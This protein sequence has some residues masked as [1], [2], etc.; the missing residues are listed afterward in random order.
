MERQ[1]HQAA[2]TA[3]LEIAR[4]ISS[5]LDLTQC[6]NRICEITGKVL[7]ADRSSVILWSARKRAFIASAD[8]GTPPDL[9]ER[10][11]RET[12]SLQGSPHMSQLLAGEMAVMHRDADD[13]IALKMLDDL[14][15]SMQVI[16]P[17]TGP[18]VLG[19]LTLG[20]EAAAQLGPDDL[21][22][23]RGIAQQASVAINTARLFTNTQKAA[24]FRTRLSELA[25]QLSGERDLDRVIQQVAETARDAFGLDGAFLALAENGS[26]TVRAAAG[27]S[28]DGLVGRS[29]ASDAASSFTARAFREHRAVFVNR[30]QRSPEAGGPML[31]GLRVE[32]VLVAPL[33]A[34]EQPVGVLVLLDGNEPYRFGQVHAEEATILAA[35]AGA[36]I[37]NSRLLSALGRKSEE[38]QRANRALEDLIYVA[39]HDL[40]G[41]LINLEGFAHELAGNLGRVRALLN[42]HGTDVLRELED[43]VG[44]IRAATARMDALVQGLLDVSRCGMREL[45]RETVDVNEVV[46]AVLEAQ[47][48]ALSTAGIEVRSARLPSAVA[49]PIG[50]TQ[51]FGN[52]IDNAIKYMGRATRRTIEI[53]YDDG[54]T[55]RFMVRDSGPGISTRDQKKIFRLFQRGAPRGVPGEGVGLTVVR[56]IVERHGGTVG[57]E[58]QPGHGATFW[59]TLPIK[60]L[61]DRTAGVVWHA[62]QQPSH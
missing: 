58:S 40:R 59:F 6:L 14:R 10:F 9:F 28:V 17:L 12:F 32:A 36:C 60:A 26:L 18:N 20:Y 2:T 29:V 1:G 24:A 16:A 5:Q 53:G 13:P 54:P 44:F 19:S 49:D 23:L 45:V 57:V 46:A 35:T 39:S 52:L 31:A 41:P 8:V 47:R 48:C 62:D 11:R 56:K 22:L 42:G 15:L 3:L 27:G 51:I 61:E 38:V 37:A 30:Y 55:Q 4:E 25:V 7:R 50:L 34:D 43:S 33:M 21:R